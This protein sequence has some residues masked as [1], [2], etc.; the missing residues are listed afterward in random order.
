MAE[1]VRLELTELLHSAVFKT[2]ALNRSAASPDFKYLYTE[3]HLFIQLLPALSN[4]HSL[5]L[6]QSNLVQCI[7]KR[8][9]NFNI[10]MPI[11]ITIHVI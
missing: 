5:P 11:D 9:L 8:L 2:D 6:P 10:K 1:E 3:Q 7:L 4:L